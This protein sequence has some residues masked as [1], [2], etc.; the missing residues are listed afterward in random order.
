MKRTAI[1]IICLSIGL[2]LCFS[3]VYGQADP[4]SPVGKTRPK[5]S[6]VKMANFYLRDGKLVF[7]KLISEDKKKIVVERLDGSNTIV[8]T[9][10]K[11]EADTRTLKIKNIPEYKYY[12]DLAE[13]FSGRTGDFKDDPDDFIGAIRYY[14]KAKRLIA[15]S[16]GA[17]SKRI[18]QVED[19]IKR[20]KADREIW[21]EQAQS[22]AKLKALEF[23]ATLES[24]LKE[25]E[26][27]V[28]ASSKRIDES[29]THMEKIIADMQQG[30][31]DMEKG[32][33]QTH[34]EILVELNVLKGWIEANRKRIDGLDSEY[35]HLYYS[36]P[37][38][39]PMEKDK[40]QVPIPEVD[41]QDK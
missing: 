3:V 4:D 26:N 2:F 41:E 6:S 18:R 31:R 9:Y 1:K 29:L 28:E 23:E 34:R 21:T 12:L 15:E 10:S 38:R 32:F 27:K 33:S 25:L 35:R 30:Y 16:L 24:R 13:Y 8:S 40:F 19:K 11:R 5:V 37:R 36:R 17:D 22:R 20:L 7:G 39:R 14:E